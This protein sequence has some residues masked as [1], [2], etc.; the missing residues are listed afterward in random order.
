M[1]EELNNAQTK[2]KLD[3]DSRDALM[4]KPGGGREP[5]HD[6][7]AA[8]DNAIRQDNDAFIRDQHQLQDQI[9]KDQDAELDQLGE[10]VGVI[11]QMGNSIYSELNTQSRILGDLESGVDDTQ[12]RLTSVMRRVNKLLESTS[13]R[14]QWCLVIV[15][16]LILIGLVIIV[17][18]V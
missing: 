5:S 4:K 18:Y 11:G 10:V 8:L 3:N 14:V 2:G 15:L 6:K 13:D 1:K 16:T 17:F 7:F 12:G 9:M